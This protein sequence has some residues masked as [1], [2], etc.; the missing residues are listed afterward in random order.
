MRLGSYP[1]R[2][3]K[4]SVAHAAYG[5]DVIAER[6]RHRFEFNNEYRAK[7]EAA[8]FV[9]SGT[10]PD[11]ELVE[12]VEIKDHPFMVGSQFHP[13]YK[14]RPTRPHPLFLGFI[15]GIINPTSGPFETNEELFAHLDSLSE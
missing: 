6:H 10:S 9:V 7:M 8:G 15:K 1:C 12:I 14:S 4:E 3:A 11:G 2:I 5:S 13:E